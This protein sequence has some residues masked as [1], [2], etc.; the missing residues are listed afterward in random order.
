MAYANVEKAAEVQALLHGL[1]LT[2][3]K[4]AESRGSEAELAEQVAGRLGLEDYGWCYEYVRTLVAAAVQTADLERRIQGS[5][6]AEAV[7]RI[8]ARAVAGRL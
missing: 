5:E 8:R 4:L 1:G 3:P 7:Q 2:G 6:E